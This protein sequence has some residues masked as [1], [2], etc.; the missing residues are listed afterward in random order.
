MRACRTGRFVLCDGLARVSAIGGRMADGSTRIRLVG[1][2]TL[3]PMVGVG[4]LAEFAVLRSDQVVK[5]DPTIPLD[6]I[7]LAGCGVTTGLG[8]GVQCRRRTA[9]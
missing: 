6:L 2:D 9:R 7:C 8:V 5:I 3:Y 1:G 4:S